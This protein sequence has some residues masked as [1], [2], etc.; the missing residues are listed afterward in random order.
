MLF[1]DGSAPQGAFH[2]ALSL[3]ALW[4]LPVIFICENNQ[5]SMGTPLHRTV[6]VSDISQ[7]AIAYGMARD[8][9]EGFDVLSIKERFDIA[10]KRAREESLPTLIEVQ[11]YRFRGHSMS[12]PGLYRTK[13]ELNEY[14]KKDPVILSRAHAVAAGATEDEIKA[15]DLSVKQEIA[16][17][18]K[19]AEESP[20][21]AFEKLKEM[22]Y[23][24]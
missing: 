6:A 8:R 20:E 13:D 18:V 14:K 9:F 2:E 7:K 21:L 17:G 22:T 19:F 3:A 4:K 23:A 5:Y 10:V 16:D 15:I 24:D 11:T 12:D 1:G